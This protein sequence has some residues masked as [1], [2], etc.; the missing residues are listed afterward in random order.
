MGICA[1]K[2]QA[3]A[4]DL[5][6]ENLRLPRASACPYCRSENLKKKKIKAERAEPSRA[7]EDRLPPLLATLTKK[8]K[9]TKRSEGRLNGMS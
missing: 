4:L 5:T 3:F 6:A 8:E 2:R 9:F 1:V 7:D